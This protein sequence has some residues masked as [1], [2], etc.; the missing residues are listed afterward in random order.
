MGGKNA[1]AQIAAGNDLLEPGTKRQWKALT[2]AAENGTLSEA[3]IDRAASRILT[4]I[5][6]SKKMQ[7]YD[8]QEN[9]DLEKHAEITRNSAAEGMVLLKNEGVLP[10]VDV[11]NVALLGVTSYGFIAGGTGSG[12]VNEAYSVSL[13]EGLQNAGFEINKAGKEI[14]EAHKAANEE[15]FK[16]LEGIEAAFNPI[17]PPEITYSSEQLDD[18][19]SSSDVGILTLGRNAGEGGDR[20]EKDDFLLSETEQKMITAITDGFHSAGKKVVVVLNIGGVIETASWK[21]Q[22]D[23]IVLAWQGGQEGGNSVAD[24]LKGKVNP[25]GK[26]PMTFPI[27]L[28]DH[29]S[30]AN[31][32]KNPKMMTMMG[33]LTG[34]VFPPEARVG[35]ERVRDEDY[36]HYDEGIYVG[37]RHFDRSNMAVSYPFGFG[38]SYAEFEYGEME[39]V[40]ENDTINIA[41]TVKNIGEMPGKEV[42]QMY[43]EKVNSTIDRPVQELKAFAK[44]RLLQPEAVDSISIQIP[45]KELRYW[46]EESNGWTLEK[47]GYQIKA[48]A[49][50]RDIRRTQEIAL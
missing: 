37:Y 21:N 11:K 2:E 10:L 17:I 8:Y 23:A 30:N 9:P 36:T 5:F 18:I 6:K 49:S 15:G 50:S 16:K 46:D 29:A 19:I 26:L 33:M 25:S 4:L 27:H 47:G 1:P 12:D 22:P 7:D 48:G 13:E 34:L 42:I 45:V 28:N 24:I 31:F 43:T 40:A 3:D 38:M 41:L 32:P 14:F 44:T 20:V 35:E 39:V